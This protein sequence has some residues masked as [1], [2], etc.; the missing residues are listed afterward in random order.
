M[1]TFTSI[2]KRKRALIDTY[3]T[4]VCEKKN[5]GNYVNINAEWIFYI[6]ILSYITA[7]VTIMDAGR[8]RQKAAKCSTLVNL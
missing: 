2:K 6:L 7:S 5:V 1:P 8:V 3:I 4:T